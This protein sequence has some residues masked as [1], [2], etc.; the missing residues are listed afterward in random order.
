MNIT[1][2]NLAYFWAILQESRNDV[3]AC[4]KIMS[5]EH[6]RVSFKRLY[7]TQEC[8]TVY[9][10]LIAINIALICWTLSL[11]T[12]STGGTLFIIAQVCV[13]LVLV[14]EVL[15]RY[16]NNPLIFW[17]ECSNA[18]DMFVMILAVAS[19]L[20]YITDP[21]DYDVAEQGAI[22]FRILRDGLQILRLAVFLKNRTTSEAF[23]DVDFDLVD[24]TNATPHR[25]L[26]DPLLQE[27]WSEGSS[28]ES[29]ME[30]T[31]LRDP[32]PGKSGKKYKNQTRDSLEPNSPFNDKDLHHL[33]DLDIASDS[34]HVSGPGRSGEHVSPRSGDEVGD[35]D[36]LV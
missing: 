8:A 25:V 26:S 1:I 32:P 7:F 2:V 27:Q 16:I 20:L 33:L 5:M 18:F 22:V 11:P 23:V 6:I 29:D 24:N 21:R 12:G 9:L 28:S 4:G 31:C 17:K 34:R 15:I 35:I 14:F 30:D 19:H 10:V 36:L 3:F 13:N